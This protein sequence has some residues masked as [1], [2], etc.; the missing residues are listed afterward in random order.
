MR[1]DQQKQRFDLECLEPRLLL[2]GDAVV[3]LADAPL[4]GEPAVAEMAAAP[5]VPS[6]GLSYDPAAQAENIFEDVAPEEETSTELDPDS[7]REVETGA[8][9]QT[10]SSPDPQTGE[11]ALQPATS[12]E[13]SSTA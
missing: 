11:P 2:S 13:S 3:S 9:T 4:T 12:S 7:E 8:S 5:T 10:A 1:V 6:A